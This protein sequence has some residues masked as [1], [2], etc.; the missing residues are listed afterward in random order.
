MLIKIQ[1]SKAKG[2]TAVYQHLHAAHCMDSISPGIAASLSLPDCRLLEHDQS[3][4]VVHTT[5]TSASATEQDH[6][7]QV[8]DLDA[9]FDFLYCKAPPGGA[10][11]SGNTQ[12]DPRAPENVS[13]EDASS[14]RHT[15]DAIPDRDLPKPL[16]GVS[17]SRAEGGNSGSPELTD[18]VIIA[19]LKR[20]DI[21]AQAG[22]AMDNYMLL[23]L[24]K[25]L[26]LL[27]RSVNQVSVMQHALCY[28]TNDCAEQH[29]V[30][31]HTRPFGYQACR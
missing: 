18:D 1:R 3:S 4:T 14:P 23:N 7:S 20:G 16:E 30:A 22:S 10:S 8:K 27:Q 25:Q 13:S 15:Q 24:N 12:V 2:L 26:E 19:L 11:T 5:H 28:A 29:A 31:L 17:N 6:D 21:A 9:Y